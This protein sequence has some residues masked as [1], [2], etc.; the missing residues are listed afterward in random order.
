MKLSMKKFFLLTGFSVFFL[1]SCD[2]L[3][4]PQYTFQPPKSSQGM[5]CIRTCNVNKSF[6]ESDCQ[7]TLTQCTRGAQYLDFTEKNSR[8]FECNT[9]QEACMS[10]V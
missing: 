8:E 7:S 9:H 3:L 6:Q 1:T 10:N 4:G 5:K 2:A